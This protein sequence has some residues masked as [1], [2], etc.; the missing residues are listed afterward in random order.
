MV[1]FC[2]RRFLLL[3][4]WLPFLLIVNWLALNPSD[5][6]TKAR[7]ILW[8]QDQ[9]SLGEGKL[10][11]YAA[12]RSAEVRRRALVAFANIQDTSQ[13]SILVSSLSD[14]RSE[15]RAAA[16]FAIGQT[17]GIAIGPARL[18]AE[19]ALLSAL[20]VESSVEVRRRIL[21]ALG[22][23]GSRAVFDRL[24]EWNGEKAEVELR[25]ELALSI[26][27]FAIRSVMSEDGTKELMLL[28]KDTDDEVRWHAAYGFMRIGNPELLAPYFERLIELAGDRNPYVRMYAASALGKLGQMQPVESE[29]TGLLERE[30][31]WRVAVNVLRA[32]ANIDSL[33]DEAISAVVKRFTDDNEHVSL[34]AVSTYGT[35]KAGPRSQGGLQAKQLLLVMFTDE[36]NR[37]SRRQQGEAAVALARLYPNE[38]LP[39]LE[40]RLQTSNR[41]KRK[42]IEA[43]SEIGSQEALRIVIA[44]I[45]DPDPGNATAAIEASLSLCRALRTKSDAVDS[46]VAETA[47]ALSRADLAVTTMAAYA[48]GD[49]VFMNPSSV[50][51]LMAAYEGLRSPEDVEPMAAILSTLGELRDGRAIPT[52]E[53]ALGDPDR[54]VGLAASE[55]LRKVTGKEG[56]NRV[57]PHTRPL[58]TDYDWDFLSSLTNPTVTL[59]TSKGDVKLELFPEDAPFTVV[60]FLKLAERGFYRKLAFHRV[61]SNFVVQGGDPRGDG[62]GGP[63]YAIRSEFSSGSYGRG[64]LGMASAGKDT[65]GS[66]FFITHSPQP[67]LDGRYTIFGRVIEGMDV[68]DRIQA[69][70]VIDS[71]LVKK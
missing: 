71:V 3:V 28:S 55:A 48:L 39:A 2:N 27:R 54:T 29:L 1:G 49:S 21:E 47:N 64:T 52:L 5:D 10:E 18:N 9:R 4:P 13:L 16:A 46:A 59:R 38:M 25:R 68:V 19:D 70:D 36:D 57:T 61:V 50:L 8:L 22:K 34:T 23:F 53:R 35:A 42:V 41:L 45:R 15:A 58:Y 63:G 67:H 32:L 17:A 66:Q 6:R 24:T 11:G 62:W 30:K 51:P 44:Q 20:H 12:D 31:D 7:D 65:E 43:L 40:Q 56:A 60:S 26:A 37:F 14:P 69:G 33:S